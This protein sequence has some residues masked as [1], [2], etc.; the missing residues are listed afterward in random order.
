M[1]TD[2]GESALKQAEPWFCQIV[3]SLPELIW[4]C[5]AAGET[6]YASPKLLAYLGATHEQMLRQGWLA[7]VHPDD[8]DRAR[9]V[10][11]TA[12]TTGTEYRSEYRFKRYDGAHRWV[13]ARALP[14]RDEKGAVAKWF[15]TNI[16]VHEQRE[17]REAL[18]HEQLRLEKMAAASPQ[19]LHSFRIAPDGKR[20]LPYVSPAFTKLFGLHPEEV[21]EDADRV[22]QL[23]HPDDLPGI[24]EAVAESAR[25]MSPWRHEWRVEIPGRGEVW[26]EC[27]SMPVR[28][29]D[30]GITWHGSFDDVTERKQKESALK[31]SELRFRQMAESIDVVFWTTETAPEEHVTY[32]SPA[33]ERV[34]GI[35]P[36]AFYEEPRRWLE[37]VHTEDRLRVTASFEQWL[38]SPSANPYD[39]EYRVVRPDGQTRWVYDRGLAVR[40]EQGFRLIGV[41]ADITE[42]KQAEHA[43][44]ESNERFQHI[45]ESLNHVFWV[46]E[47]EPAPRV[48]YVSA[49]FERIWGR[50]SEELYADPYVWL[51]PIDPRDR[52]RVD[53]AHR[54]WLSDIDRGAVYD[55]EYRIVRGDGTVRWIHDTAKAQRNAEGGVFR[56]TG[57][58]EDITAR[59][60]AELG[61][62]EERDRLAKMA[63]STPVVLNSYR[64]RPDGTTSFPYGAE[65][66]APLYDMTVEELETDASRIPDRIHPDD[67][68]ATQKALEK[69]RSEMTPWHGEYRLLH[70]RRGVVWLEGHSVPTLESDGSVVWHGAIADVTARK[71]AEQELRQSRA[72]LAAVIDNLSEGLVTCSLDGE[73]MNFNRVAL[74]MYGFES[75]EEARLPLP[76]FL[77]KFQV[78]TV[79]G[80]PVSVENF[81]LPRILR[82]GAISK[83]ELKVKRV[84][85]GWDKVFLYGGSLV[86]DDRGHPFLAMVLV[87][88]VTERRRTE[89]EI[90]R[91]NLELEDRVARR[92]RELEAANR[93]LEAFCYSISHDLRAPLRSMDGFSQALIEDYAAE[94]PDEAQRFL[95]TIRGSARR[96]SQLIDDLLNF[97]R[98]GRRPLKRAPID[99][100][101]L[102]RECLAE[103]GQALPSETRAAEISVGAMPSC[104]GDPSL[105]RQ[106]FLNLLSNALKYSRQARPARIEIG[107]REDPSGRVVYF[108]RDNGTGFD[109]AYAHRL[110][111]VFQRLHREEDFEGTGV[112]L[113]IVKRIVT[114]HGGQ[115]WAESAPGHGATFSFTLGEPSPP[116]EAV[117]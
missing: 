87:S 95:R 114:R 14:L 20:T 75:L 10:W 8:H 40:H 37:L 24:R 9:A 62:R 54:S 98:L 18:E 38:A 51:V 80:E 17:M 73:L 100:Q 34:W 35:T 76:E 39:I 71:Q 83:L 56:V 94:L 23:N 89:E 11:R 115:V 61:Y 82:E 64:W 29:S 43:L 50:K 32:V 59:K 86:R 3:E 102:V 91:L 1:T 74:S 5:T 15:G 47:L 53:E 81:P 66:L 96:M 72:Q 7:Y 2:S 99:T 77:S 16:D 52:S 42:R 108:V 13:E 22:F 109:M 110:F 70:S 60:K 107:S 58:A 4:T 25:T 84:D 49:A 31:E 48:S 28:D 68:A 116:R 33:V 97:S 113:A 117:P 92:T 55:V 46:L 105:V 88:D 85:K 30:G 93:E 69:S 90:R 45:A 104:N 65:R 21:A 41:V 6:E 106:V 44:R 19:I 79:T 12:V 27:H 67:L 36:E 112:G 101:R 63:A 103:L 78:R 57:I 26:L 111:V